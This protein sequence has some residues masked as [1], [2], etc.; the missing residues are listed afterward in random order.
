MTFYELTDPVRSGDIIRAE[1]RKHYAYSFGP[2]RWVRTTVMMA[3][4]N[5]DSPLYGKYR[6]VSEG[7]ARDLVLQK[8]ARLAKL[9][10][11]AEELARKYHAR[12]YDKAGAPYIEHPR[13]VAAQLEDLEQKITAWLHDLCEDTEVTPELLLQEG[14]TPRI[15]QAVQVLTRP[16]GMD[17]YDYIRTIRPNA[18]ARAVKIADLTHN[19]DLSRLD[20]VTQADEARVEKYRRALA[21]LNMEEDLP[22]SAP[23]REDAPFVGSMQIFQRVSREALGGQKRP[24]GISNPVLRSEAGKVYLAFFV[25]FYGKK[26]LDDQQMPRPSLWM[27]AD[28]R[29]GEILARYTCAERDFSSQSSAVRYSVRYPDKPQ[30]SDGFWTGVYGRLDRV[31]QSYLGSGILDCN[32]YGRYLE[33]MLTMVPP[34]Y[35]VFYREL[36]TLQGYDPV[37]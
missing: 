34:E 29:T 10:P 19:M 37:K 7:E 8:S 9:L 26:D 22:A 23:D 24:H 31:R 15:V 20:Q 35:R 13:A 2:C 11:K 4:M 14:F 32:A 17:Y 28:V 12:Q 6:E 33:E 16:K 25:Y 5:P 18:I 21:Y 1:G 36:S 30:V 3:Y 27:L